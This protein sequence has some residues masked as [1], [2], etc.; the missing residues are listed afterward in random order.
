MGSKLTPLAAS[1]LSRV[2]SER[3]RL[4]IESP[5]TAPLTDAAELASF[6]RESQDLDDRSKT[7]LACHF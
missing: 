3:L 7:F 1:I 6:R 4:L 5:H 2:L